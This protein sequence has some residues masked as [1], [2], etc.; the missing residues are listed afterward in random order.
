MD[1]IVRRAE[2]ARQDPR[3]F[4]PE[5]EIPYLMRSPLESLAAAAFVT[6]D[7]GFAAKT[8]EGIETWLS[9]PADE[10]VARPHRPMYCD[11]A[12]LNVAAMVGIALDLCAPLW[13]DGAAASVR[14]RLQSYAIHRF[15]ET[16]RKKEVHWASPDYHENWKIMCCGEAGTAALASAESVEDLR[17]ILTACLEGVLD[18]LDGVPDE[19]DWP[20][21]A[22]YWIETLGHGLRFGV[23]L[24]I[25]TEGQVNLFRHP[26][27]QVTGDYFVHVTEPDGEIYNYNDNAV[28]IGRKVDYLLLLARENGRPDWAWT[29]RMGDPVTLER[30]AWDDPGLESVPPAGPDTSRLFP[31][32]GLV[33]M[34]SGWDGQATYVGFKSGPSNVGHSHLDANSFVL[35]ARGKRLLVDG[36]TWP[37]AHFLGFFG[38]DTRFNF[39]GNNTIAHSTLMVDGRGQRLG[40]EYPGRIAS[41]E[42]GPE[43][44]IAVGDAAAAYAGSLTAFFRALAFVKPDLLLVYDQVA[45]DELRLL[46]WLFQHTGTAE[47]D[48]R[49]TTICLDGVSLS[50]M[51]VL[52]EE[53]ECWRTSDVART[54]A[55]TS[56]NAGIPE[57]VGIRYRSFGPFHPCEEAQVL[58]AIHVGDHKEKP[59]VEATTGDSTVDAGI[60]WPD[61]KQMSVE[62]QRHR[63]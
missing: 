59:R 32:T 53:S 61:G 39:D 3:L 19:G 36:G 4:G 45:A 42:P 28:P 51:R 56:S 17:E 13:P 11:H 26:A 41:F 27:L 40:A 44:D 31:V 5:P 15:I 24:R 34:R 54:S 10:W 12:L 38:H 49:L 20:E 33:T 16:W 50:L 21:G 46:E 8:L 48:E 57:R 25:A 6:E 22:N 7:E 62:I 1:A 9:F 37:Y 52:P 60:T 43:V 35:S 14:D 63:I 18:V 47:G 2:D 29:A 23:G 55:Y 30:L 58:W